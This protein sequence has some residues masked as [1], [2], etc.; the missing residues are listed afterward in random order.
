MDDPECFL[1]LFCVDRCIS[2]LTP[3]G[4]GSSIHSATKFFKLAL[5]Y[6]FIEE[7]LQRSDKF[8]S[9]R[10]FAVTCVALYSQ[11]SKCTQLAV[12]DSVE[13]ER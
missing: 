4:C 7:F 2:S 9:V 6:W 11:V 10:V 13:K 1:P 8:L 3:R 12:R 5:L